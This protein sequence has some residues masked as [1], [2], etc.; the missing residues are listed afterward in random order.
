MHYGK[1]ENVQAAQ[2]KDEHQKEWGEW[3]SSRG[4]EPAGQ[5]RTAGRLA[6]HGWEQ[7]PMNGKWPGD[8]QNRRPHRRAPNAQSVLVTFPHLYGGE[9]RKKCSRAKKCIRCRLL[10]LQNLMEPHTGHV[11]SFQHSETFPHARSIMK[12]RLF[13]KSCLGKHY[14]SENAELSVLQKARHLVLLKTPTP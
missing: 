9:G 4:A 14:P 11:L 3:A 6:P 10:R 2:G 7:G 1:D 8:H 12:P 13:C 5:P